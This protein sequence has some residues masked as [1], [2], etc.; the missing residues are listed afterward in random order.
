MSRLRPANRVIIAAALGDAVAAGDAV[1][2]ECWNR[3]LPIRRPRRRGSPL[4]LNGRS[5]QNATSGPNDLNSQIEGDAQS[6]RRGRNGPSASNT[7]RRR[8]IS[9]LFCPENPSPNIN[10]W[11]RPG[12]HPPAKGLRCLRPTCRLRRSQ[13]FLPTMNR[14]SLPLLPQLL[15]L[16]L[17]RSLRFAKRLQCSLTWLRVTT[18]QALGTANS[19]ACTR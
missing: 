13:K 8:D 18:L 9:L 12:L 7:D 11:R 14:Y 10:G 15:L 6:G 19:S 16:R 17:N 4:A 2:S 3:G 5:R 1:A